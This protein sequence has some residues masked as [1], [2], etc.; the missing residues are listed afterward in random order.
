MNKEQKIVIYRIFIIEKAL[1]N[2]KNQLE[3]IR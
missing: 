1:L 2:A 3:S